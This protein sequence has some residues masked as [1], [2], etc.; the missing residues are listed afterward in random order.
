MAFALVAFLLTQSGKKCERNP[1]YDNKSLVHWIN[2]EII[3][4]Q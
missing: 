2:S 3:A 1:D 4:A